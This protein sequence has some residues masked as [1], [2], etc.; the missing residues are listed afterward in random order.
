VVRGDARGRELGFPTANVAV[1]TEILLPA[2]GIYAGWYVGPDGARHAAAIS[3]GRR[4]TFYEDAPSSLLEA[5]LLDFSGD[6]YGQ[7][8]RVQ[9]VARLRGELKFD[10]V[11]TLVAQI[12]QDV[13]DTRAVLQAAGP[14]A[15]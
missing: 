7:P 1:P 15:V 11:D 5:H 6:L 8:A 12:D 13:A 10:D 9:F 2:D 4:P 14:P 3:L